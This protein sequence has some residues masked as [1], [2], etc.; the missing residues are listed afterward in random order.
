MSSSSARALEDDDL[1]GGCPG[2]IRRTL[3][4][5]VRK[6]G[7]WVAIISQQSSA[8]VEDNLQN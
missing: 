7:T 4:L 3:S 8:A 5:V 6:Q 2:F 1:W